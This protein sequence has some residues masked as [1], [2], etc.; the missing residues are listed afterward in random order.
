MGCGAGSTKPSAAGLQSTALGSTVA[1]WP[2]V[3]MSGGRAA[4]WRAVKTGPSL[5]T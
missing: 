4:N 5:Q 2:P 3:Y 1:P